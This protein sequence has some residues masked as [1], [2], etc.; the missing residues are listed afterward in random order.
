MEWTGMQGLPS[1]LK[2]LLSMEP[3]LGGKK[4]HCGWNCDGGNGNRREYGCIY[5]S[6]IKL[7]SEPCIPRHSI[8]PQAA[9]RPGFCSLRDGLKMQGLPS[10]LRMLLSMEPYFRCKGE[11]HWW[12]PGVLEWRH[13]W[14]N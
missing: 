9:C 8:G 6:T 13:R 4:G 5:M 14:W 10:G 11:H 3:Y 7:Q 12:N 1:G 2:V